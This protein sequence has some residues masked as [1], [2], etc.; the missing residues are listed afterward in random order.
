MFIER[1][2]RVNC[3]NQ[4]RSCKIA[5][6][7]LLATGLQLQEPQLN[8]QSGAG[9]CRIA[10]WMQV[11][12]ALEANPHV[13]NIRPDVREY[14]ILHQ[15]AFHGCEMA[16]TK[17]LKHWSAD[18]Q[19]LTRGGQT[20]AEVA[21][22]QGHDK[23][24]AILSAS[25]HS[26]LTPEKVAKAACASATPDWPLA[27]KLIDL[28]RDA[29]WDELLLELDA[30]PDMIN[31]RPPV[32]EYSILHQAIFHGDQKI[33]DALI[34][35]FGADL[36]AESKFGE[37]IVSVA[38]GQGHDALLKSLK[39][40]LGEELEGRHADEDDDFD[41]VQMPNGSWK[42][43]KKGASPKSAELCSSVGGVTPLPILTAEVINAAH[44]LLDLA[45]DGCWA[46]VFTR[47]DKERA[48]VNVRPAVREFSLLHQAAWQGDVEAAT[49]LITKY[50]AD[51]AL[52]S[53]Q[54]KTVAAVAEDEGHSSSF[55]SVLQN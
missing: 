5:W 50:G 29:L 4:S 15:A 11:F 7:L 25:A 41:M 53:K 49:S 48:L 27:H 24:A 12:C 46:K 39:K 2:I 36:H 34:D 3:Q 17:L 21:K 30:R 26:E 18:M 31:V 51:Q 54:G 43:Q 45:K 22:E 10:C 16:V 38:S 32:R 42:I 37:K 40:R 20:A 19:L 23:V 52:L 47:L 8:S 35:K 55:G 6:K 13:I 9:S 33:V 28:A 14:G 44:E 1:I